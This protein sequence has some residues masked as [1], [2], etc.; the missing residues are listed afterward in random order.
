VQRGASHLLG[1]PLIW[2]VFLLP[3]HGCEAVMLTLAHVDW[4]GSSRCRSA[5]GSMPYQLLRPLHPLLTM[6]AL[7]AKP[8][9]G[10]CNVP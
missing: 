5:C 8:C 7:I 1:Q 10:T 6:K 4:T 9:S 2:L 3:S